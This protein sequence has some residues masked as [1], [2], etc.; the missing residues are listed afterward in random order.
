[1]VMS[2]A[3][4]SPQSFNPYGL[5]IYRGPIPKFIDFNLKGPIPK[6]DENVMG[7]AIDIVYNDIHDWYNSPIEEKWEGLNAKNELAASSSYKQ[8]ILLTS[9]CTFVV[10]G[11]LG[12]KEY[13]HLAMI[14]L[15]N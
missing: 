9:L 2:C 5:P 7:N 13:S 4:D 6:L 11:V 14:T 1:M 10:H 3:G 15:Y 8:K 12:D